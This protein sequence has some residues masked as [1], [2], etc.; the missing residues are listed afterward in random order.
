MSDT[1]LV[2]GGALDGMARAFPNAPAPWLDL[3]TG[4]NPWPYRVA[5]E[6]RDWSRLPSAALHAACRDA[7]ARAW[8]AQPAAVLPVPGTELA[9]RLLPSLVEAREVAVIGPTYD[10]HAKAWRAAGRRVREVVAPSDAPGADV[11]VLCNPNNPDGRVF[12]AETLAALRGRARWLVVDEAYADVAPGV[13]LAADAGTPGLV[14]L[15]SFGKF[16]G[17]AGVR[18]GAVLGPPDLLA[19][20]AAL[21]GHWGVSGPALRLGAAA[22]ADA[23]WREGTLA[24]LRAASADLSE[25][26]AAGGLEVVGGTPLFTLARADDAAERWRRLAEAGVY[27][28]RFARDP[29][30]LRFGLPPSGADAD[31]LSAALSP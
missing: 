3:S 2:H 8:G 5:V 14:V 12:D 31:R 4:I 10:D 16:Y 15:R 19:R 27:V 18:L 7:M 22:Y 26:L 21:L 1:D 11:L 17:L 23:A 9:I 29:A 6:D 28:R 13:S 30:L 24:R 25:R 20:L